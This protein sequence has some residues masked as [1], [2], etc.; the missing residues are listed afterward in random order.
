ML[1]VFI[2]KLFCFCAGFK[3]LYKG[4]AAPVGGG[5]P[6][7]AISFFGYGVGKKAV[8]AYHDDPDHQLSFGE[9]FAAGAFSGIFTTSIMAG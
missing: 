6:I 7:F 9:L 4:M 2:N 5:A 3:G 1:S 8:L